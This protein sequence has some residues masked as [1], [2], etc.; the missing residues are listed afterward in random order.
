MDKKIY[1]VIVVGE[2]NVDIILNDIDSFPEMGKEKL[3]GKMD[4]TLGSSS[5]IFASNLSSLG[6]KVAFIGKIG[7][8]QNGEI[9]LDSFQK[10]GVE[11]S[12]IIRSAD[13]NTGAT[14]VLNFDEDR[15]NIT[16]PGAMDYLSIDDISDEQLSL[17]NHLHFSSVFFQPAIKPDLGKL[18]KKAKALGLTTSID[19][20]WDPA[21]KWDFDYKKILP[22]VDVFLPNEAELKLI[23][24]AKTLDEAVD[25]I[26]DHCNILVVKNGSQGSTI[27]HQGKSNHAKPYLNTEV[28]DAIGAGDS[29]N[30]GF[31]FKYTKK[32]PLD[33]CHIF[34]NLMGAVN[35]TKSG[36]TTAFENFDSIMEIARTKFG[37]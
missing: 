25:S 36:G 6:S 14:I 24:G 31:L 10:K 13:Y 26:K 30:T 1:D 5:A 19:P 8:D 32:C 28:V 4:T 16:Y 3:A 15:A 37:Y 22:F 20:Q 21:E 29:F 9:V 35:T 18:F 12:M 11:T 17:A 33:E 27:Y 34:G 23:T 2:L 7:Q